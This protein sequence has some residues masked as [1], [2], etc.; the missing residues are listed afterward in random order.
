MLIALQDL[1]RNL[2]GWDRSH[3]LSQISNPSKGRESQAITQ[4]DRLCWWLYVYHRLDPLVCPQRSLK[5]HILT[6]S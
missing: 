1:E 4:G 3:V 6:V 2:R 5:V